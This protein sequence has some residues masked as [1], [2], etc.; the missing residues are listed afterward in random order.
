MADPHFPHFAVWPAF[1]RGIRFLVPQEGH[2]KV[3]ALVLI[4]KAS[5]LFRFTGEDCIF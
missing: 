5:F 2:R 4:M 3:Y 1:S